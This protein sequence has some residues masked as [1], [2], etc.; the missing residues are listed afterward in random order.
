MVEM[1]QEDQ[2]AMQEKIKNMSPEELKKFQ[3]EQCIFCHIISGKVASKKIYEDKEC[4]AILDINPANPGHVL[5]IPKEHY[6][7]MPLIPDEIIQHLGIVS[8]A[9]SH[10]LLKALKAEGTT[11]FVAN[12]VT[13][14]QRAQHFMVHVI[15]RKE[16]DSIGLEIPKGQIADNVLVQLQTKIKSKANEMFGI[17]E[18]IVEEV[19]EEKEELEEESKEEKKTKKKR[20]KKKKS[21]KK[22]KENAEEQAP[23]EE[24]EEPEE[25]VEE[26][27]E[28]KDEDEPATEEDVSLDAIANLL[29]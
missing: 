7:I 18:E 12:G 24:K 9:I 13:A 15:P 11:I 26:P 4:I 5:I 27:E 23:E 1:A 25:E 8:K 17:K 10:I 20:T 19:K 3:K 14:G 29:K 28:E 2:A 22:E 21:K 16:G 6:P